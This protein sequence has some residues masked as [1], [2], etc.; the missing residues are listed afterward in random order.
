MSRW[1][2]LPILFFL[3]SSFALLYI[4][5][6]F[7]LFSAYACSPFSFRYAFFCCCSF[8]L[9]GAWNSPWMPWL[10]PCPNCFPTASN[11][12]FFFSYERS[13][14]TGG[15]I[16]ALGLPLL[17]TRDVG[18]AVSFWTPPCGW[19]VWVTQLPRSASAPDAMWDPHVGQKRRLREEIRIFW[20][21]WCWCLLP[22]SVSVPDKQFE[23]VSF[24]HYSEKDSY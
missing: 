6:H 8:A 23:L 3:A 11:F 14:D 5:S 20:W 22:A 9:P 15:Q 16:P 17:L 24:S 21:C 1:L 4:S 10:T 18:K 12:F 13:T 7:P 19:T 2:V